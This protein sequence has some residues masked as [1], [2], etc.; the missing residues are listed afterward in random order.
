MLVNNNSQGQNGQSAPLVTATEE[1]PVADTSANEQTATGGA[2]DTGVVE[3]QAERP[4]RPETIP[5]EFWDDESGLKADEFGKA[6]AELTTSLTDLKAKAEERAADTPAEA[7]GYAVDVA[8]LNLPEGVEIDENDPA[9]KAARELAFEKKFTKDEF[10]SLVGFEVK[11][12]IAEQAAY[13]GRLAE[14]R[15]KLGADAVKRI[16]AVANSIVGRLGEKGRALLPLMATAAAVESFEALLRQ[17]GT[18]FNQSGR[19]EADVHEI[20]GYE[21]MNFRQR[22]AAIEARK[23][24]S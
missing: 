18:S 5:A 24:R 11:R 3:A 8:A 7:T 23:A 21:S 9:L 2:D 17:S 16:D 14:E 20:D 22:M 15:S 10:Q 6:F 1:P 4:A 12:Q 13:N 19:T